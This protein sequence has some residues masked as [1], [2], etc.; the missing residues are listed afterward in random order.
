[1]IGAPLTPSSPDVRTPFGPNRRLHIARLTPY[2]PPKLGARPPVSPPDRTACGATPRG[3]RRARRWCGSTSAK[4]REEKT[5]EEEKRRGPPGPGWSTGHEA[6]A[7][8]KPGGPAS[9]LAY[10]GCTKVRGGAALRLV[11]RRGS[12]SGLVGGV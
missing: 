12:L 11:L 6:R 5:E 10:E 4:R 2:T 3:R 7:T 8:G 9:E 1:M